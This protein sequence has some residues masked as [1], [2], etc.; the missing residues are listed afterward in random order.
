MAFSALPTRPLHLV[1][2]AAL[3]VLL[4]TGCSGGDAE[5]KAA[6]KK[7]KAT[8]SAAPANALDRTRALPAAKSAANLRKIPAEILDYE[9]QPDGVGVR[10]WVA[11]PT[12]NTESCRVKAAEKSD[13][14]TV[15]VTLCFPKDAAPPAEG[16]SPTAYV[17]VPLKAPLGDRALLD[18][19]G[20]LVP[21]LPS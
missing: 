8:S 10:V 7:P 16:S 19:T 2:A 21:D 12:E 15:T 6:P 4:L 5:D 17:D 20:L 1:V 3:P 14:V 9:V 18:S 13:D 11:L